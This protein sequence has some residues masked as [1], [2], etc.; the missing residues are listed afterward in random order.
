MAWYNSLA[1]KLAS[2]KIGQGI[3]GAI[4]KVPFFNQTATGVQAATSQKTTEAPYQR[5]TS[6]P[7]LSEYS[8]QKLASQL[9]PLTGKAIKGTARERINTANIKQTEGPEREAKNIIN[10]PGVG[11]TKTTTIKPGE[12]TLPPQQT[13]SSTSRPFVTTYDRG[14]NPVINYL[15][16]ESG[17]GGY[18]AGQ[19]GGGT[20]VS[21][22]S[23]GAG[24]LPGS[25][26]SSGRFAGTGGLNMN[27]TIQNAQYD[28]FDEE[29]KRKRAEAKR[30]QETYAPPQPGSTNPFQSLLNKALGIPTA[31]AGVLP[32]G[33]ESIVQ[34]VGLSNVN[35]PQAGPVS[36]TTGGLG[37][38]LSKIG[39]FLSGAVGGINRFLGAKPADTLF[40]PPTT[41][42]LPNISFQNGLNTKFLEGFMGSS[43]KL[44]KLSET[45]TTATDLKNGKKTAEV[46]GDDTYNVSKQKTATVITD[47]AVNQEQEHQQNVANTDD[48][49]TADI[50]N[51]MSGGQDFYMKT[52]NPNTGELDVLKWSPSTGFEHV[53]LDQFRA[54]GLNITEIP[55][56]SQVNTEFDKTFK[57]ARAKLIDPATGLF[58][59]PKADELETVDTEK[60][61]ELEK[62][63]EAA[64]AF[65]DQLGIG[66][67]IDINSLRTQYMTDEGVTSDKAE[68]ANLVK[69][70]KDYNAIFLKEADAIRANPN[71][72]QR[73]AAK[74][75]ALFNTD[76]QRALKVLT[77]QLD[78]VETAIKEKENKVI[79]RLS[80]YV[81][82]YNANLKQYDALNGRVDKINNE[83]AKARDDDRA[84]MTTYI[85]QFG[86]TEWKELS[87]ATKDQI[88]SQFAD[89]NMLTVL[90]AGLKTQKDRMVL[91]AKIKA[92]AVGDK[93]YR[94]EYVDKNGAK[95]IAIYDQKTNNKI[96]DSIVGQGEMNESQSLTS[97]LSW[98]AGNKGKF[99]RD[100]LELVLTSLVPKYASENIPNQIEDMIKQ[101]DTNERV[102]GVGEPLDSYNS[103][104]GGQN[105]GG[106]TGGG[107][108]PTV[109]DVK[110]YVQTQLVQD[111]NDFNTREELINNI[112]NDAGGKIPK[113]D[114]EKIIYKGIP[115]FN[116]SGIKKELLPD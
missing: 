36:T 8:Q 20:G 101:Y 93:T 57:D 65:G 66:T 39:G 42:M 30:K 48:T 109:D 78:T 46:K 108:E 72:S 74:R 33:A 86:G 84:L 44:P 54:A 100:D 103:F 87:Q 18:S 41:S 35:L 43:V 71:I 104:S 21:G 22:I 67:P 111:Q 6:G 38:D 113:P 13:P 45:K 79:T 1:D 94:V 85:T 25:I 112:Y 60:Q 106:E 26:G 105:T 95:R 12:I 90:E 76:S 91:D 88:K 89:P 7:L 56:S 92:A 70:I 24:L 96:S 17:F 55:D 61:A 102:A 31:T 29:Q 32:P 47:H 63:K 77:D 69:Q 98:M 114:I 51:K 64:K 59:P 49:L 10:I 3:Y 82:S 83:I 19:F 15:Q 9:D 52:P 16:G 99:T 115:G 5:T 40:T 58:I 53:T 37:Q 110:S 50:L 34:G 11:S 97:F 80:D 23:V 4:E 62:A 81:N 75:L 68:R 107:T 14:G 73:L 116:Y 28:L 2:T 27:G